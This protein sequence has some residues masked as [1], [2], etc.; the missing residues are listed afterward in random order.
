MYFTKCITNIVI[1]GLLKMFCLIGVN[2]VNR[3][4]RKYT[5][6]NSH[7]IWG[8][9]FSCQNSRIRSAQNV[10]K[11]SGIDSW[12]SFNEKLCSSFFLKFYFFITKNDFEDPDRK[13][14]TIFQISFR[15]TEFSFVNRL[16]RKIRFP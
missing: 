16:Q 6:N 4:N 8:R 5:N 7:K 10:L 11:T 1:I 3:V 15:E 13:N 14:F 2:G 9:F 12:E